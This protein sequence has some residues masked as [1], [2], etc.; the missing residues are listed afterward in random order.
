MLDFFLD[1]GSEFKVTKVTTS[2]IKEVTTE[3]QK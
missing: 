1:F 2:K 3:H